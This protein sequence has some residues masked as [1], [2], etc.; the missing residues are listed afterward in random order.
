MNPKW[1]AKFIKVSA[2][3]VFH[4]IRKLSNQMT[5]YAKKLFLIG[6]LVS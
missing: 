3:N 2:K 1:T 4:V 5:S 6:H